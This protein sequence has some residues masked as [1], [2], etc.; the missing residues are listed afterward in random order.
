M[1]QIEKGLPVRRVTNGPKFHFFGYFDKFPWDV[2]G[3]YLLC[4]ETDFMDR[5]P[6]ADDRA[7]ICVID[8]AD[9]DRLTRL[10]ETRAFCWQQAS[11]LQWTYSPSGTE[12]I[13]NDREGDA[14][15]S[16]IMNIKTGEARTVCRPVY[17]ISPDGRHAVSVNFSR[18]DRQRP[19]YGYAGVPD[20][21]EGVDHPADDGIYLVDLL[22]NK[23]RLIISLDQIARQFPLT[24]EARP[25]RSCPDSARHNLPEGFVASPFS[26]HANWFNHLLFNTDGSRF[27]FFHRWRQDNGGHLTRM[28]TADFDGSNIY[29]LNPD[30]MSSH[31][32]WVDRERIICYARRHG[33]GDRYFL[34]T[35]QTP[36]FEVIGE[37]QFDSDG[38]CTYSPD[39]KWML[40]DTYPL[41][42]FKRRRTLILYDLEKKI[43][44]NVGKFYADPELP[45]SVRCDL[46]PNWARDGKTVCIDSLH[47][48]DR[49]VYLVDVSGLTK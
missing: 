32:A 21:W 7:G 20:P 31:Y 9:G 5:Q 45:G 37:G 38:H 4:L 28:F 6:T 8:L 3:R 17:C 22:E 42:R 19:G 40:T 15:V 29:H 34:F 18:L 12:I 27:A 16:R 14:F 36:E 46:H 25:C 11:M 26:G 13:Y 44:Y 39:G 49:Q 10:A 48:G 2:T 41:E 23:S 43:R 1:Q 35:D 33:F 30:D 47:E 24:E